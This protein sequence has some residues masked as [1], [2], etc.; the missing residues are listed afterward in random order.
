MALTFHTFKYLEKLKSDNL[1]FGETLTIDGHPERSPNAIVKR[2]LD[3]TL[4][5]AM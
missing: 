1:V 2:I 4:L 5:G 3:D